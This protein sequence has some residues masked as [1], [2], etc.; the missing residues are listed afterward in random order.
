MQLE[1]QLEGSNVI[2]TSFT[3]IARS[4]REEAAM[5]QAATVASAIFAGI[6]IVVAVRAEI[7][8]SKAESIKE[9][10]GEKEH[11]AYAALKLLRDGL[12][13]DNKDRQLVLLALMQAAVFESSD[14]ARALIYRVVDQNRAKYGREIE[15]ALDTIRSTFDEMESYGFGKDQLD[16]SRGRRRLETI[17]RVVENNKVPAGETAPNIQSNP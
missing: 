13:T 8:R 1:P 14:R 6:A 15:G 10:L 2:I 12:P 5:E 11:V 4:P 7:Q 17:T 16:L 3:G 9:L